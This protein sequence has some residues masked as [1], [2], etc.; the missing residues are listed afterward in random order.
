[1]SHVGKL[2]VPTSHFRSKDPGAGTLKMGR[3]GEHG[4]RGSVFSGCARSVAGELKF[5]DPLFNI[6]R[7]LLRNEVKRPFLKYTAFP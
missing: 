1:M 5:A 3:W 2:L 6:P 7:K 4:R